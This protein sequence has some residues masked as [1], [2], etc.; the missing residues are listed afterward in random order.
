MTLPQIKQNKTNYVTERRNGQREIEPWTFTWWPAPR[1]CWAAGQGLLFSPR[2]PCCCCCELMLL[3]WVDAAAV[4]WCCCCELMLLCWCSICLC[5]CRGSCG[6]FA[7]EEGVNAP[8]VICCGLQVLLLCPACSQLWNCK[9]RGGG[10]GGG[11]ESAGPVISCFQAGLHGELSEA[12]RRS[13]LY[14]W[15]ETSLK[16]GFHLPSRCLF[17]QLFPFVYWRPL[18]WS[19]HVSSSIPAPPPPRQTALLSG[20]PN[21]SQ[22]FSFF[23]HSCFFYIWTEIV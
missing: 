12:S 19:P 9:L 23:F 6:Y 14:L 20:R 3:L 11:G 17:I 13:L 8:R 15:M 22:T 10:R 7:V 21:L 4:S 18:P 1:S 2:C 5:C 16:K